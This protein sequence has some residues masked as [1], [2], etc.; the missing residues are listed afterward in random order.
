[1]VFHRQQ[2]LFVIKE[3]LQYASDD[4]TLKMANSALGEVLLIANDHMHFDI[5]MKALTLSIT[6]R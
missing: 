5:M 3:A 2:L 4:S 6:L 1:M